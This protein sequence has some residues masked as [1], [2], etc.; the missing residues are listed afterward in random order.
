MTRSSVA[1]GDQIDAGRPDDVAQ[2]RLFRVH[3]Q[4]GHLALDRADGRTGDVGQAGDRAGPSAGGQHGGIGVIEVAAFQPHADGAVALRQDFGDGGVL[5]QLA[6]GPFERDAERL[7]ELAVVHLMVAGAEDGGDGVGVQIG[8]AL[9]RLSAGQPLVVEA[10]ALLKVEVEAQPGGIVGVEGHDQRAFGAQVD[11]H[12]GGGFQLRREGGPELLAVAV[13]RKLA[14]LAGFDLHP[15]GQHAGGGVAGAQAGF[16][17]VE[18]M[19]AASGGG[20][21]PAD[22]EADHAGANDQNGR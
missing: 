15:G 1:A 5:V 9:L 11:R 18:D 13:Q 22:A 14:F 21:T 3:A 10:E 6:A 8:F 19:D 4:C 7:G 2:Q 16:P 12:A 20:Q 17:L